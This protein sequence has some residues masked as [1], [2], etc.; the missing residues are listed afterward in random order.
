MNV[1]EAHS[2]YVLLNLI[3]AKCTYVRHIQQASNFVVRYR[4]NRPSYNANKFM[5]A[6]AGYSSWLPAAPAFIALAVQWV[7]R[8]ME[9]GRS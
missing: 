9:S 8:T 6:N 5:R 3:A 4:F 1:H 2:S 7:R